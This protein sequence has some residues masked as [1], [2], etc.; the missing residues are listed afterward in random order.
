MSTEQPQAAAADA[1]DVLM[2][3]SAD[4][5]PPPGRSRAWPGL[6]MALAL[7]AAIATALLMQPI[8]GPAGA[9]GIE[10]EAVSVEVEMVSAS[11]LE[12]L[13]RTPNREDAASTTVDQTEGVAVEQ[14]SA[15][16]AVPAETPAK[17]PLPEP[18]ETSPP[19]PRADR[20]TP[21]VVEA[22]TTSLAHAT[23]AIAPEPDAITL[24]PPPVVPPS[25]P[26]PLEATPDLPAPP[27]PHE[28][29]QPAETPEQVSTSA[30][31]AQPIGGVASRADRGRERPASTPAASSPGEVRAFMRAVVAALA[32]TRPK[33]AR[34]GPRGSVSIA[35]AVAEGG[36]LEF[37][38]VDRSSGHTSLDEAA[39]SA[40][41]KSRLPSPPAGLS[42]I[43]RTYVV[44]YH[45][46]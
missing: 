13:Y 25:E 20:K 19:E 9:R 44:P 6:T 14:A 3:G 26:R 24:P 5:F 35:F 38:R 37:V 30:S 46:R 36:G 11:A 17:D 7:H 21:D 4:A 39:V 2:A 41:R 22:V 27:K 31:L 45:F 32:R 8:D 12:S 23:P 42:L 18:V 16:A 40:V 15:P 43:A 29:V 28:A 1:R 10:L 34:S 33:G